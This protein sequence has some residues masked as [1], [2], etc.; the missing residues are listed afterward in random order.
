[1]PTAELAL[2]RQPLPEDAKKHLKN[3]TWVRPAPEG[4]AHHFIVMYTEPGE[5]VPETEVKIL[6]NFSL[7]DGRTASVTAFEHAMSAED[8]Q[9]I[10]AGRR[11]IA[12]GMKNQA[13]A[14]VQ[15]AYEA[16]LEPRGYLYGHDEHGTRFFIESPGAP[17]RS[18]LPIHRSA[19]NSNSRKFGCRIL[20]VSPARGAKMA[21]AGRPGQAAWHKRCCGCA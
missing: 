11:T 18:R 5:P 1:M 4:H 6:A 16:M 7:P 13:G 14:E 21:P 20:H 19:W 8:Q 10:E 3:V 15:A 2:P 12:E 17:S 9:H